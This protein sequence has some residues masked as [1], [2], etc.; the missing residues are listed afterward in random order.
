[1]NSH[2]NAC[3]LNKANHTEGNFPN[4]NDY[5]VAFFK[6]YNPFREKLDIDSIVEPISVGSSGFGFQLYITFESPISKTDMFGRPI[7]VALI[8]QAKDGQNVAILK[9][10]SSSDHSIVDINLGHIVYK[11]YFNVLNCNKYEYKH[12]SKNGVLIYRD[13]IPYKTSSGFVESTKRTNVSDIP[14]ITKVIINK[15]GVVV[16]W[17]DGTK[18]I[19]KCSKK[20]IFDPEVGLAMAISRKYYSMTGNTPPRCSFKKEL[21][22]ALCP[23]KKRKRHNND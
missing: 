11:Y 8:E 6:D 5:F 21:K 17:S 7:R 4:Y 13:Y 23:D 18:T 10:D 19:S 22:N 3:S 20:D 9:L 1:M 12:D 14:Q 15:P 16:F 2:S